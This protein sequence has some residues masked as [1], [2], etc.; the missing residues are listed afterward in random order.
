MNNNDDS[1]DYI[2]IVDN[3]DKQREGKRAGSLVS[4]G[5]PGLDRISGGGI[6]P[7]E[8]LIVAGDAGSGTTSLA[9]GMALRSSEKGTGR[10]LFLSGEMTP[11]RA[12]ARLLGVAAGVSTL[13]VRSGDAD[14][15]SRARLAATAVEL[16]ERGPLVGSA[17]NS[18]DTIEQLIANNPEV[19]LVII[20]SIDSMTVALTRST[21][22]ILGDLKLL[23]LRKNVAIVAV[24]HLANV[25]LERRPA[26]S[27]LPQAAATSAAADIALGIFREEVYRQDLDISGA[28]EVLLLKHR[29]MPSAYA[30]LFYHA[31]MLRFDDML[32]EF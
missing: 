25:G 16:R 8:L 17:N 2:A 27:D 31:S 26:L 32:D 21:A 13:V 29:E 28:A 15:I 30:D 24:V 4:L 1:S 5:F 3:I 12:R 19:R 10:V 20:D 23:S 14:D 11:E 6:L 18:L 7:G 9:I 22:D